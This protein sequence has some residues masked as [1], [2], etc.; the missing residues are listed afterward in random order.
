MRKMGVNQSGKTTEG[1]KDPKTP[2]PKKRGR[3]PKAKGKDTQVEGEDDTGAD[4]MP[5][6]KAKE[7]VGTTEDAVDSAEAEVDKEA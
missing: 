7:D 3:Q 2:T 5:R 6:K 4:E 1:G